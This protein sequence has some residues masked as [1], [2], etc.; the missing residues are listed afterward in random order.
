M[1]S[2]SRKPSAQ[3]L[4]AKRILAGEPWSIALAAGDDYSLSYGGAAGVVAEA[5]GGL[6]GWVG[7]DLFGSAL[8]AA[9]DDLEREPL[10][11][12]FGDVEE[13]SRILFMLA[14]AEA[15]RRAVRDARFENSSPTELQSPKLPNVEFAFC[16]SGLADCEKLGA[17]REG[18][19]RSW[20]EIL[21]A[22]C[23]EALADVFDESLSHPAVDAQ[24]ISN[25]APEF[26]AGLLI[27][28]PC[29]PR[30]LALLKKWSSSIGFP[31]GRH[32]FGCFGYEDQ[33]A[34]QENFELGCARWT[35]VGSTKAAQGRMD[36]PWGFWLAW[37]APSLCDSWGPDLGARWDLDL[38]MA[39]QMLAFE[40]DSHEW[41]E[42]ERSHCL[43]T[44]AVIERSELRV[45]ANPNALGRRAHSL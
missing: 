29:R 26:V 8:R 33:G 13:W 38:A 25:A 40:Y 16:S 7:G 2:N 41:R 10:G 24:M 12:D 22:E 19:G 28:E 6:A 1:T 37:C 14:A 44:F 11:G 35:W 5:I 4:V 43:A 39:K 27:V 9:L 30:L 3:A 18:Q 21:A 36:F 15:C 31:K 34:E 20:S 32:H 23:V 42:E 45:E 17:A